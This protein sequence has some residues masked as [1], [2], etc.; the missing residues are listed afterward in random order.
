MW[1]IY[2]ITNTINNKKYIGQTIREPKERWQEHKKK[3]NNNTDNTPLA[4]A[5]RKYGW[6]NFTTEVIDTAN[7]QQEADEKEKY[8]I[9]Y[10][11]TCI[12]EFGREAGYN[13][14]PGGGGVIRTT[15]E[16]KELM[17]KL[18]HEKYNLTEISN[19]LKIDRHTIRRYLKEMGVPDSDFLESKTNHY[20]VIYEYNKQGDLLNIFYS[21][22]ELMEA[23][24][25]F[26]S[27]SV[28]KVLNHEF[29]F[30]YNLIFLY[31]DELDKLTEHIIKCNKKH[32]G[33]IKAIYLPTGQETI[34]KSMREA[35]RQTGI[36]RQTIRRYIRNETIKNNIKWE[37]LD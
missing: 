35:E 32:S 24:P 22:K 7:S 2:K 18:W 1:S 36:A 30:A 34:Y 5:I 16:Q 8:W 14:T 29:S 19:L 10:Y 17:F 9:K 4:R 37:D 20:K 3:A 31:E 25:S 28:R 15:E 11:K 33:R 27:T 6:D 13:I 21:L 26:S 12:Q 23:H